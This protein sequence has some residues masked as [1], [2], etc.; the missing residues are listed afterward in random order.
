VV[1]LASNYNTS[2]RPD[3]SLLLS[4][5]AGCCVYRT[6]H[7]IVVA[8]SGTPVLPHR[9]ISMFSRYF[10]AVRFITSPLMAYLIWQRGDSWTA[11]VALFWVLIGNSIV[12][13]LLAV[14]QAALACIASARA[15]AA[16]TDS[17]QRRVMR[18]LGYR[19]SGLGYVREGT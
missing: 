5:A 12:V 9:F 3:F 6:R 8:D 7:R 10:V 15:E 2:N 16:K 1:S 13:A 4:V 14:P 19:T 17:I 18:R 11:A